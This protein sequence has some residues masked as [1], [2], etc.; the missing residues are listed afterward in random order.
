MYRHFDSFIIII[1]FI[2]P[3]KLFRD[4]EDIDAVEK[5]LARMESNS[6]ITSKVTSPQK[7]SNEAYS[8][9][10]GNHTATPQNQRLRPCASS[11][12]QPLLTQNPRVL[13]ELQL[14][15]TNTPQQSG[16]KPSRLSTSFNHQPHPSSSTPF[17]HQPHPASSCQSSGSR[18]SSSWQSSGSRSSS[19]ENRNPRYQGALGRATK[20]K[21]NSKFNYLFKSLKFPITIT[22]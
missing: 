15:G 18:S 8:V 2:F 1:I 21:I 14:F 17:N 9:Q 10:P 22:I 11:T 20:G 12:P 7:S 4:D 6:P 5:H 3:E 13:K 16:I 19:Q